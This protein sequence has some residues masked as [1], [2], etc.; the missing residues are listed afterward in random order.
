[1]RLKHIRYFA[2]DFTH[3]VKLFLMYLN[4]KIN[5]SVKIK[6]FKNI[7]QYIDIGPNNP[8]SGFITERGEYQSSGNKRF[9]ALVMLKVHV[10]RLL[11]CLVLFLSYVELQFP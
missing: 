2:S 9:R 7:G 3:Y 5:S 8:V 4:I 6:L 10:N 1:M 11:S